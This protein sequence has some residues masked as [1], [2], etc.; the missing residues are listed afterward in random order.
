MKYAIR[1]KLGSIRGN[2]VMLDEQGE[3]RFET[4]KPAVSMSGRMR[5]VD[6][7]DVE[8]A[9]I[10]KKLF[11]WGPAYGVELADGRETTM[12]EEGWLRRRYDVELGDEGEIRIVRSLFGRKLTFSHE[13]AVIAVAHRPRFAIRTLF[14]VEISAPRFEI[15]ILATMIAFLRAE[16]ERDAKE[17]RAEEK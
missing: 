12:R 4:E 15:L 3:T 6:G 13:G 8:V 2:F 5:L 1:R 7:A 14:T 17:E 11:S 9:G 16:K 10:E